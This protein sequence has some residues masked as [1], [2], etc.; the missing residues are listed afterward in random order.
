MVNINDVRFEEFRRNR[1]RYDDLKS[2]YEALYE[3][4][5]VAAYVLFVKESLMK[6]LEEFLNKINKLLEDSSVD[7]ELKNDLN[8]ARSQYSIE[9]FSYGQLIKENNMNM[10][11]DCTSS[12]LSDKRKINRKRMHPYDKAGTFGQ[13]FDKTVRLKS[14]RMVEMFSCL[15]EMT[16]VKKEVEEEAEEQNWPSYFPL[17]VVL[18]SFH[19]PTEKGGF[20][21]TAKSNKNADTIVVGFPTGISSRRKKV[22][23]NLFYNCYRH[24]KEVEK[25]DE[26]EFVERSRSSTKWNDGNCFNKNVEVMAVT[27]TEE[28]S[29]R[30]FGE[31]C[32]NGIKKRV[33]SNLK[34]F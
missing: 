15:Q 26:N 5:D 29:L 27:S 17:Y 8:E 7:D 20:P 4:G 6:F 30:L 28:F 1:Q 24:F 21:C 33:P 34:N 18:S 12:L 19:H 31:K 11:D 25:W 9:F 10:K 22:I 32:W 13:C 2:Q 23:S 3:N 14:S 16:D